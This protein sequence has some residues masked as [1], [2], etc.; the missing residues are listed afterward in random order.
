MRD[1]IAWSYDLL[2]SEEQSLFRT[3][4]V[5]S[6]G[7]TLEHVAAV[8]GLDEVLVLDRVGSQVES[9]L[10]RVTG[11]RN[12]ELRFGLLETVRVFALEQLA[13]SGETDAVRERLA[14][15]FQA[16]VEG[17]LPALYGGRALR[18]WLERLEIEHDNLRAALT[19]FA[20]G[21][22]QDSGAVTAGLDMVGVLAW[23]WFVRGHLREG[24]DWVER[25]LSRPGVS[26]P[27]MRFRAYIG[28]GLICHRL[29]EDVRAEAVLQDALALARELG[30]SPRVG[31]ALALL[32]VIAEDA[33]DYEEAARLIDDSLELMPPDMDADHVPLSAMM[34]MHR[35]VV[36]WGRGDPEGA[37]ALGWKHWHCIAPSAMRGVRPVSRA[38]WEW[39]RP[40]AATSTP[41]HDGNQRA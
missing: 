6:S 2:T 1:A 39:W 37:T 15:V 21:T 23:S 4:G 3:L 40:N 7:F 20:A 41:P 25:M 10:V 19:W 8:G 24:R 14:A 30:N 32:G 22:G 33:G 18:Q 34:L 16:M 36:A 9:S 26:T 38:I 17:A 5:F 11:E 28:L 12:G 13:E 29:G 31:M 35:G 27:E